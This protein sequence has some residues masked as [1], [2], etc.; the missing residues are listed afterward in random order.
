L[1][2]PHLRKIHAIPVT[3]A[4]RPRLAGLALRSRRPPTFGDALDLDKLEPLARYEVC[5]DRKLERMLT[6]LV[7]LKELRTSQG[8]P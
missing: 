7:K 6:M 1:D 3:V 4:A 5:L 2:F 8:E